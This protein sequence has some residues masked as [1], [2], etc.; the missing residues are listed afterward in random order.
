MRNRKQSQNVRMKQKRRVRERK[1]S[2]QTERQLSK[3]S[4][5]SIDFKD[6]DVVGVAIQVVLGLRLTAMLSENTGKGD[7]CRWGY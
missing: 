6:I 7:V 1:L 5:V 3:L 4:F 2:R